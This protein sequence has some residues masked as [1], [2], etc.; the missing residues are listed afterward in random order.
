M[1]LGGGEGEKGKRGEGE[2]G[3]RGAEEEEEE[4]SRP[5]LSYSPSPLLPFYL[6]PLLPFSPSPF[7]PSH[8]RHLSDP[9]EQLRV[10]RVVAEKIVRG[11]DLELHNTDI[12][13]VE[14][15]L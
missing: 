9:R 12:A 11:F 5:F 4:E 1:T 15:L 6:S 7:S 13:I 14:D 3:R 10:T 8:S 2:K